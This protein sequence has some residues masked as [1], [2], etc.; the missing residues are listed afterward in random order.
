M[1]Q[2]RNPDHE[3]VD[4]ELTADQIKKKGFFP[5]SKTDGGNYA[6]AK[7]NVE[8]KIR[9]QHHGNIDKEVRPDAGPVLEGEG[10]TEITVATR[11]IEKIRRKKSGRDNTTAWRCRDLRQAEETRRTFVDNASVS[12]PAS[13]ESS[14]EDSQ[15]C[16]EMKDGAGNGVR[17]HDLRISLEEVYMTR[18]L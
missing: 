12:N 13:I 15:T 9:K 3:A 4:V 2:R 10:N 11:R 7:G 1:K 5:R 17:T 6:V 8:V 14:T 16:E 18:T